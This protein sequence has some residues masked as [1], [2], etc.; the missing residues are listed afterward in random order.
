MRTFSFGGGVQSTA[1][2]VLAAQGRIDYQTFLFANVGDDSENPATI[3]YIADVAAPYAAAHGIDLVST[4]RTDRHGKPFRTLYEDV[5]GDN[6]SIHIPVYMAGGAPGRRA[7]TTD[8]KRNVIARWQREHGAT[9]DAPAVCGLGISMDEVQ[10]MRL[11]SGI[12]YQVLEYP[13]IDLHMT[14]KDCMAVIQEAGLPVP[15]KSSC[16]F[17]PFKRHAQWTDMRRDD[18]ELFER[19]VALEKRINEK[20]A[21]LGRDAVTLHPSG[22]PLDVAVGLQY[23]LFE[24]EP[25]DSG[26]CFV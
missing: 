17:C 15:P 26:Y 13:L 11:D 1:A 7:C 21:M 10:R 20:R 19:A 24:D 16:W 3:T 23:A 18:P 12:A 14:R 9:L 8:W 5:T 6:R 4:E 22:Q 2:L 25:C